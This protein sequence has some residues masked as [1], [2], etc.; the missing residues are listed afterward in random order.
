MQETLLR[1]G[2]WWRKAW[3]IR[4]DYG[5]NLRKSDEISALAKGVEDIKLFQGKLARIVPTL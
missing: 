3:W 2:A 4:L 1:E 5:R